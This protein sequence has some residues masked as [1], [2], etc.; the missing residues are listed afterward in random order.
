MQFLE[1]P[2]SY[3]DLIREKLKKSKVR[4]AEALDVL[5]VRHFYSS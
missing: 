4:V 3:Y 2:D 1:V 5:Q